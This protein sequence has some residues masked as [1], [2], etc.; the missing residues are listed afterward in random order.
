M[1]AKGAKV[2]DEDFDA[3]AEYLTAHSGV[4]AP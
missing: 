2:S 3:I 4:E 1:I